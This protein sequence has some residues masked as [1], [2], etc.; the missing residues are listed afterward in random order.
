MGSFLFPMLPTC[1]IIRIITFEKNIIFNLN[2][3]KEMSKKGHLMHSLLD[4]ESTL[5]F[6]ITPVSSL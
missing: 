1:Y 3:S 2:Y 4:I 5:K 6:G